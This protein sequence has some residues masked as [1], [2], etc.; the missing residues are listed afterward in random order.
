VSPTLRVPS[1]L[2]RIRGDAIVR[3]MIDKGIGVKR[4]PV[5]I[6]EDQIETLFEET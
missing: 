5:E 3:L 2:H 1:P 4:R 6:Y